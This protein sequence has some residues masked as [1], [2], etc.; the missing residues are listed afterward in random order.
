MKPEPKK[1]PA[2]IVPDPPPIPL[3][4]PKP[5]PVEEEVE[6]VN[7]WEEEWKV[8]KRHYPNRKRTSIF[9]ECPDP[10][11]AKPLK[12][13]LDPSFEIPQID[14]GKSPEKPDKEKD[15]GIPG[16]DLEPSPLEEPDFGIRGGPGTCLLFIGALALIAMSIWSVPLR[17]A[18]MVGLIPEEEEA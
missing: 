10:R 13:E 4:A 18:T 7:G 5:S 16:P 6:K 8:L 17:F 2:V 14:K 15:L 11:Y 3:P 1:P 12:C 9:A